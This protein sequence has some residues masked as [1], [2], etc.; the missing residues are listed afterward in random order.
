MPSKA[1]YCLCHMYRP[2]IREDICPVCECK[3]IKV[4]EKRNELDEGE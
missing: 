2:E 3:A 4:I 1:C